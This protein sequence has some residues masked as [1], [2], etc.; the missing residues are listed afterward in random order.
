MWSGYLHCE[1]YD[2]RWLREAE[3]CRQCIHIGC[4]VVQS[5][6]TYFVRPKMWSG[7]GNPSCGTSIFILAVRSSRALLPTL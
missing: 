6:A 2:V 7:S 4:K 5:I 1:A 3:L